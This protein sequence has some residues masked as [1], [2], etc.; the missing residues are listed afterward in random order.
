MAVLFETGLEVTIVEIEVVVSTG[1]TADHDVP[2]S[3]D[4]V[5][6][7]IPPKSVVIV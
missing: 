6:K 4:L 1:T 5:Y 2:P 7:V 3:V